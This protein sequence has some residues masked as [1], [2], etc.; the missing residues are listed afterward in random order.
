MIGY[1][2]IFH[3]DNGKE[4]V[5]KEVIK[6]LKELNP[7]NV[8]VTGCPRSPRDRGS[9]ESMNKLI[10]KVLLSIESELRSKG[11][12]PNWTNLLG[13]VMAVVNNQNGRG[14]YAETAFKAVFGQEYHQH[15]KCTVAEAR[16]C[17]TIDERLD[18]SNDSRLDAVARELCFVGKEYEVGQT[19]DND[20]D[21]WDDE[22]SV[23]STGGILYQDDSDVGSSLGE[24]VDEIIDEMIGGH[25][26]DVDFTLQEVVHETVENIDEHDENANVMSGKMKEKVPMGINDVI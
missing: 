5:A 2:E 17:T 4:F 6:I 7:S 11:I 9:V 13:R 20:G 22:G 19:H 26:S 8:T 10:K 3:T 21:Y 1:P 12:D 18:I 24:I 23:S 16:N 15:L 14:R 25:H